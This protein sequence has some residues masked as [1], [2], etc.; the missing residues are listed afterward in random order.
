MKKNKLLGLLL[1]L[2][3]PGVGHIYLNKNRKGIVIFVIVMIMSIFTASSPSIFTTIGLI[4]GYFY[5]IVTYLREYSFYEKSI[6]R[7]EGFF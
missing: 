6:N 1:T 2:I 5:S 4:V 7:E 3:F